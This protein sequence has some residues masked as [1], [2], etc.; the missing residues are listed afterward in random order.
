MSSKNQKKYVC[1]KCEREFAGLAGLNS[2]LNKKIPCD[3]EIRKS[4][5][6]LVRDISH[7]KYIKSNEEFI[8]EVLIKCVDFLYQKESL[9]QN[10]QK[11][12]NGQSNDILIRIT[13]TKLDL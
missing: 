13:S 6:A 2:H 4:R 8:K 1:P 12:Q 7:M 3:V 11:L 5:E 9:F 10:D